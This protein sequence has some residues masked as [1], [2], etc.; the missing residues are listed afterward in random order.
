ME[1]MVIYFGVLSIACIGL[2]FGCFKLYWLL[3]YEQQRSKYYEGCVQLYRH[4]KELEE[5]LNEDSLKL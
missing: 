4:N 1:M 5:F 2:L 3:D